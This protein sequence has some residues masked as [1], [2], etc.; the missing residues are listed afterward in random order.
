VRREPDVRQQLVELP[1]GL[2][3]QA[4]EDIVEVGERVDVVVL[5]LRAILPPS[6][7]LFFLVV[8]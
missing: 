2:G 7:Q 4:T 5:G 6:D 1:C 3:R 8:A